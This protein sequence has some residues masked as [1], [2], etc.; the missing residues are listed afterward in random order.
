MRL[1]I[2]GIGRCA[3]GADE[4]FVE[5]LGRLESVPI[6]DHAPPAARRRFG[7]VA[8]LMYIAAARALA[9]AGAEID[10]RWAVVSATAMG[11]VQ[12]GL[13]LLEQIHRRGGVN[14]SPK[15]VPNAVHNAP[16]GHLTIGLKCRGP[17]L[18]VSQGWLSPEAGLCAAAD[19]VAASAVERILLVAGD[20]VDPRWE[21]RLS[22]LDAG[23]L[24][25]SLREEAFQEGAAALVLGSEPGGR[26]LG[27]VT[28]AL[29]RIPVGDPE[30]AR[31]VESVAGGAVEEAELRARH[32]AGGAALAAELEEALGRAVAVDGPGRG[33]SQAGAL[34]ALADHLERPERG[35]LLLAGRELDELALVHYRG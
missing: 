35:E 18:T 11:E 22:E 12:V 24:A 14:A 8:R 29:D 33:S 31:I 27:G 26:G 3:L 20:E 16:A 25:G 2:H 10:E 7:R 34:A 17:C 15:L 5:G 21:Q 4:P 28:A 13:D 19:L 6:K 30:I 23:Q 1:E 9:D 32:G